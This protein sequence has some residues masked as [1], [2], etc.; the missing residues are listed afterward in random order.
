MLKVSNTEWFSIIYCELCNMGASIS[1]WSDLSDSKV[2]CRLIGEEAVAPEDPFWNGLFS[3]SVRRPSTWGEWKRFDEAVHPLIVTL[4]KNEANSKNLWALVNVLL[5]RQAELLSALE[6]NKYSSHKIIYKNRHILTFLLFPVY[7]IV[8][9]FSM[10]SLF[11]ELLP[12]V[13]SV[14]ARTKSSF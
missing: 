9:N 5:S 13:L 1:K 7:C 12:R 11:C 2:L 4:A 8:G 10:V 3:V 6:D 14:F